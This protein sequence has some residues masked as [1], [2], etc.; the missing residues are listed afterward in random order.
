MHVFVT[1][2][3]RAELCIGGYALIGTCG[4]RIPCPTEIALW[5]LSNDGSSF[6]IEC[7]ADRQATWSRREFSS[8]NLTK[9]LYSFIR[10]ESWGRIWPVK[11]WYRQSMKRIVGSPVS[12][13]PC[14]H[15]KADGRMGCS[16]RGM[17]GRKEIAKAKRGYLRKDRGD[18]NKLLVAH[19]ITH[20]SS[21]GTS[22][23]QGLAEHVR[24]R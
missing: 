3:N 11:H 10:V 19:I 17:T 21:N 18:L 23:T 20:Q 8:Y 14:R 24:W 15:G 2:N 1:I 16:G 13:R 4:G 5:F 7:V 22:V 9:P 6:P 12:S